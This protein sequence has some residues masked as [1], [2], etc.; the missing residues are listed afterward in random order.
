MKLAL[1]IK[2]K[3]TRTWCTLF[4][5]TRY[6]YVFVL[7]D[8]PLTVICL[9]LEDSC[10]R[11]NSFF[12]SGWTNRH[13]KWT[14]YQRRL[15]FIGQITTWI[16]RGNFLRSVK[17]HSIQGDQ[18]TQKYHPNSRQTEAEFPKLWFLKPNKLSIWHQ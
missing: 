14:K 16:V 13:L 7:F 10:W 15:K 17:L 4:W 6:V 9:S 8:G 3:I 5:V 2:Y 11:R 12:L 18:K 1:K